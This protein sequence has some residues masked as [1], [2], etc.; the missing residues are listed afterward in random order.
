MI[1]PNSTKIKHIMKIGDYVTDI[2]SGMEGV[3]YS[4]THSLPG[5][6]AYGKPPHALI[7][8]PVGHDITTICR[9]EYELEFQLD[10]LYD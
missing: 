2:G 1:I 5:S 9:T 4:I 10:V 7:R 6:M 3:I 8:C